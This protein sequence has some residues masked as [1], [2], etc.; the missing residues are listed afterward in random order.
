MGTFFKV[1]RK[2]EVVR[3]SGKLIEA[4]GKQIALIRSEDN[5]FA[6]DNEC[7]H[8]GGP[9]CEGMVDG[10]D[11][12]CPWHA[13]RFNLKSGQVLTGPARGDLQCYS[14]R[15]QGDNIEVEV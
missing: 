12:I 8:V 14:V 11:V 6:I 7:T 13:A 10:E 1:A 2:G 5:F 3:N 15:I 4:G 9:L